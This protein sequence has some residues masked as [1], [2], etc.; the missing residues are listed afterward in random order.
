MS[1]TI[2]GNTKINSRTTVGNYGS[3]P[4]P[5]SQTPTPTIT[6]TNTPTP[7]ITPTPTTTP[8]GTYSFSVFTNGGVCNDTFGTTVYSSSAVLGIGS[9]L[10]QNIGLTIP[11][12]YSQISNPE[13][14]GNS[15]FVITGNV[16]TSSDLCN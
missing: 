6:P 15:Y 12:T 14:S 11:T 4:I 9:S 8:S 3:T 2:R 5:P 10:Y 7:T 1:I 16:I 13:D